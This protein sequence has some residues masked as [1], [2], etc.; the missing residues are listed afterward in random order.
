MTTVYNTETLDELVYSI[1]PEFAVIAANEQSKSYNNTWTYPRPENHPLYRKTS[2][3]HL[4]GNF[5]AKDHLIVIN[6]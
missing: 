6:K 3:G 2:N 5:W 4:C 1:E